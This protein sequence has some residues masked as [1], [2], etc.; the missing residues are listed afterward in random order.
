MIT[1]A[2]LGY[3]IKDRNDSIVG[4]LRNGKKFTFK[5]KEFGNQCFYAI[6]ETREEIMINVEKGKEYFVRCSV[7]PGILIA[8]PEINIIENYLGIKE[9]EAL[10]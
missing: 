7:N 1:G 4:K 3:N 2:L 8:R 9:F 5:T 10:K 6:L